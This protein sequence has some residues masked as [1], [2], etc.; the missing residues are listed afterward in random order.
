MVNGHPQNGHASADDET[1]DDSYAVSGEQSETQRS[2]C[3]K[4]KASTIVGF[5]VNRS[6][7]NRQDGHHSTGDEE[8][9]SLKSSGG[10]THEGRPSSHASPNRLRRVPASPKIERICI[11]NLSLA[12]VSQEGW[13]AT[14]LNR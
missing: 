14:C 3:P 5:S 1:G 8:C 7:N 4:Q 10:Q 13:P 12:T 11:P 6:T 2:E 9:E